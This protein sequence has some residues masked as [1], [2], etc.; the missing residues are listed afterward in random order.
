MAY[1]LIKALFYV[2]GSFI[3]EDAILFS[4]C[5]VGN[6][7]L[8]FTIFPS[9]T[10]GLMAGNLVAWCI[11]S[12][13]KTFDREAKGVKRASF[14][15]SMKDL[16]L[17]SAI[18]LAVAT[19]LCLLGAMN[20]FYVDSEGIHLNS[21]FSISESHYKWSD[22]TNVRTRCLAERDNLHLNYILRMNDEKEVDLLNESRRE[23]IEVYS[24]ITSFLHV[25]PDIVYESQM[26]DVDIV[27]LKKR[28]NHQV[29]EKILEILKNKPNPH[30][31]S[32][33]G[34]AGLE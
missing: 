18:A 12:A 10:L 15:R 19:P 8:V 11:K 5:G 20:Y 27:R 4:G 6:I 24:Q 23:F 2:R 25:H 3:T 26:R 7:L 33:T 29:A 34:S 1:I 28:Y 9:I 16:A 22:I 31:H 21:L 13:R 14:K 32:I 30:T 17:A